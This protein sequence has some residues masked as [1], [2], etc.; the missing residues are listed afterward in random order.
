MSAADAVYVDLDDV[1]S[2]TIEGLIDL[3][4]RAHGRRVD[5]EDVA[6]FDLG[7]SF[8]LEGVE[9][10]RFFERAHSPEELG[11]LAPRAGARAALAGW[12]SRGWRVHIVTGRPPVCAE[13]SKAW[14][15]A[16]QMAHDGLHFV[17]KYGRPTEVVAGV[18]YE[19]VERMLEMPFGFAVEDS[20]EM[21][22]RLA[23]EAGW[24]VALVDRPWNRALPEL[25]ADVARR[26]V[27][28]H[29]WHEIDRA[30][31]DALVPS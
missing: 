29:D 22:L 19:P 3:L 10:E 4:G 5:V 30:M 11:A 14:L 25:P 1:L 7:R 31:T 8:A 9:L 6:H 2:H 24:H 20:L 28:C 17:D 18:P 16:H 12:R 23:S 27:R 26:I 21:A 15:D 13:A